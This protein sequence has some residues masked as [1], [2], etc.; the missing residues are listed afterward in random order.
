LSN[1]ILP[2]PSTIN[3]IGSSVARALAKHPIQLHWF[4]SSINHLHKGFSLLPDQLDNASRFFQHTNSLIARQINKLYQRE[5]HLFAGRARHTPCVDDP[6]AEQK[7]FYGLSNTIKDGL[8]AKPTKSPFFSTYENLAYGKPLRYWFI[9]WAAYWA[10]GGD[11]NKKQ[12]PKDFIKWI[13]LNLTP[14]PEWKSMTLSQRQTR[15]RKQV[16]EIV[17][18][19]EEKRNKENKRTLSNKRLYEIDPFSKPE[20]PRN[21]GP[22]PLCH[23]SNKAARDTYKEEWREFLDAYIEA[24]ADY[25][26]G[27]YYR[28]FPPGSFKPPLITI[29]TASKL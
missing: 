21:S 16:Q 12:T 20:K 26:R 28:Y 11:E 1:D 13:K 4:E 15:T 17:E 24:S 27:D 3:I 29:Y 19:V 22:Q 5:G 25:F 8:I 2:V 18:G 9:D 23:A 6:A 10:K 14:L 7:L